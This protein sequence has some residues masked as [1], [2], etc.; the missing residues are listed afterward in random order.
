MHAGEATLAWML[1][2]TVMSMQ[3]QGRSVV[4]HVVVVDDD[5]ILRSA[6]ADYLGE[7]H[8]RVTAVADGAAMQAVISDDV[9]D[10]VVL[11][12]RP[13]REGGMALARKLRG[14]SSIPILLLTGRRE[15]AGRV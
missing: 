8:F 9:V 11:D 5:P 6:V 1:S 13:E 4:G 12:V 15:E 10:L 2:A 3:L 14:A 7:Q